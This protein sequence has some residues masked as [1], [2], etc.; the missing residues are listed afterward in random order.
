M[1]QLI[2]YTVREVPHWLDISFA[3]GGILCDYLH[4]LVNLVYHRSAFGVLSLFTNNTQ[5]DY[6]ENI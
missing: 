4:V 5:S 1:M 3:G 6:N 2:V